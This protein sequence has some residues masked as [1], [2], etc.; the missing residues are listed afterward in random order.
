M[1]KARQTNSVDI[2]WWQLPII[3]DKWFHAPIHTYLS[4]TLLGILLKWLQSGVKNP[5]RTLWV[6]MSPRKWDMECP[7]RVGVSAWHMSSRRRESPFKQK[8]SRCPISWSTSVLESGE[9]CTPQCTKHY[10][11]PCLQFSMI[12]KILQQ[13]IAI[14]KK[15]NIHST[16][17]NSL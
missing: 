2:R 15:I 12:N 3:N 14:E 9:T 17:V 13:I 11:S 7:R 5:Q 10:K 1:V 8:M 6:G 16:I 4:S